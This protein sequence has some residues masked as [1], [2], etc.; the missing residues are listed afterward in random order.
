MVLFTSHDITYIIHQHKLHSI[1]SFVTSASHLFILFVQE[2]DDLPFQHLIEGQDG[3]SDPD[4]PPDSP[5]TDRS[6]SLARPADPPVM[7]GICLPTMDDVDSVNVYRPV[8]VK[9][10]W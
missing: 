10:K 2:L 6:D 3:T 7:N 1:G 5:A 9:K 4:G 8:H